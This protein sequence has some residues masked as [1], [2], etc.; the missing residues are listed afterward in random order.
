M[1]KIALFPIVLG[2]VL[3]LAIFPISAQK[4]AAPTVDYYNQKTDDYLKTQFAENANEREWVIINALERGKV[5]DKAFNEVKGEVEKLR[6]DSYV[7]GNYAVIAHLT[8]N[9]VSGLASKTNV[10]SFESAGELR[11]EAQLD[12]IA[13]NIDADDVWATTIA[14][15]DFDGAGTTVCV[16]DSGVDWGNSALAPRNFAGCNYNCAIVGQ[17]CQL[18]C[19]TTDES[20]HGTSV[21]GIVASTDTTYK[22]ISSGAGIIS[23][24]ITPPGPGSTASPAAMGNAL[25]ACRVLDVDVISISF[26]SGPFDDATCNVTAV[27]L[28]NVINDIVTNYNIP[29]VV[30]TGNDGV[31]GMT[32]HPACV[33]NA[34]AVGG[35]VTTDAFWGDSNYD[36]ETLLFAQATFVTTTL[37]G[38][39]FGTNGAG[40]SYSAPQVSGAIAMLR[41]LDD[42]LGTT[43]TPAEYE[44]ILFDGGEEVIGLPLAEHRRINVANAIFSLEREFKRGDAN[45]D[46]TYDISDPVR[47]LQYLFNSPSIPIL[48]L[49]SADSNDDGNVDI[50]DVVYMLSY[51]FENGPAMPAPF[52]ALGSDTTTSDVL[53][54][55]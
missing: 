21:A 17:P 25:L 41:Q 47:I 37:M 7:W 18:D 8:K 54:C 46:G 31:V 28:N 43:H 32:N 27:G 14:N 1:R 44:Q 49:D 9:E 24:R 3:L 40:T 5:S 36:D 42:A 19:S 13:L 55:F 2:V 16:I 29:V 15:E 53:R 10:H 22:G 39:G 51:M 4:T 12:E 33:D 34:I 48:C 35:T 6:V 11:Y 38:G 30:A 26:G 20:G 23:M 45:N 50:A 52:G